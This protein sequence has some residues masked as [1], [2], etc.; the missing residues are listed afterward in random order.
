MALMP[1]LHAQFLDTVTSE[2]DTLGAN[3]DAYEA[4]RVVDRRQLSLLIRLGAE[5]YQWV[6]YSTLLRMEGKTQTSGSSLVVYFTSLAVSIE[7]WHLD[8]IADAI[9]KH[10]CAYVEAFD[11]ARHTLLAD[12]FAPFIEHLTTYAPGETVRPKASAP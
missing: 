3:G 4:F 12:P 5:A 2:P 8:R 10:R 11:L 6:N 9:A 7:G 1:D